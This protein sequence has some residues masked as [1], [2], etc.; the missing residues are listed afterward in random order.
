MSNDWY[1]DDGG[2]Q[3]GPLSLR[4]LM[5]RLKTYDSPREI[6]VW[7]AGFDDWRRARDVWELTSLPDW[8]LE[9]RPRTKSNWFE[10]LYLIVTAPMYLSA[11]CGA[12]VIFSQCYWW[13]KLAVWRPM[14]PRDA[15]QGF[16]GHAFSVATGYLGFDQIVQWCLDSTPLSLWL[17]LILPL[18]WLLPSVLIVASI[19]TLL[20]TITDHAKDQS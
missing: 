8:S 3:V 13:L 11:M 19:Y 20:L 7:R 17:I 14:T 5:A 2:E 10:E 9:P 12:L 1:F 15:I 6:F 18:M 16:L 4:E